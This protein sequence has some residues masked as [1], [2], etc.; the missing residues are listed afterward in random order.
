MHETALMKNLLTTI[1]QV[2]DSHHVSR[3]NRVYLSVGQLSNALPEALSFAFEA[4]TREG[5]LQ[6]AELIIEN[7]PA[8]ARCES[9]GEEYRVE[10]FPLVCP[11]CRSTSF[12]IISG[13]E[14]YVQSIDCEEKCPDD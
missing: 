10:K 1:E 5:R 13:E 3:V 8:V 14:V 6:G 12:I 2:L 7:R 11:T 9:C 4:M